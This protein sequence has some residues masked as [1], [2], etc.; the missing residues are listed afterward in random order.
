LECKYELYDLLKNNCIKFKEDEISS[1]ILWIEN[2]DYSN[3]YV[4]QNKKDIT[5]WNI[6]YKKE[7][8]T[9]LKDNNL[10]ANNLYTEYNKSNYDEYIYPGMDYW[11]DVIENDIIKQDDNTIDCIIEFDKLLEDIKISPSKYNYS[12]IL[13]Y[14]ENNLDE[15]I[16]KLTKKH[17]LMY[18]TLVF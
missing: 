1:I 13:K 17:I 6:Y 16:S 4:E 9:A 18:H 2:L 15:A 8:L 12:D 3:E 5:K 10:E 11:M 7:W 14:V